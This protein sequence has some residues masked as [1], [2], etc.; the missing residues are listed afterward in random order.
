MTVRLDGDL[1]RLE[2]A[3]RLEEAEILV[4]LLQQ[5]GGRAVDLSQ[6]R[7]LHAA[8]AQVLLAL[9]PP[10]T[11]LPDEP[12]LRDLL[13]PAVGWSSGSFPTNCDNS[14]QAGIRHDPEFPRE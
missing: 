1:I 9:A 14:S 6:A 4:G 11:A 8:V 13:A 5:A 7:Q 10:C 2:G 12:F 3:C